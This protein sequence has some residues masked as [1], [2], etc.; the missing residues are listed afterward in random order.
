MFS[1]YFTSFTFHSKEEKMYIHLTRTLSLEGKMRAAGYGVVG[2]W[3]CDD[4]CD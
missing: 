3:E 2:A 4:E 1:Q